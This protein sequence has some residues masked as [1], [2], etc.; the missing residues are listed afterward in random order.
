[1]IMS[2]AKKCPICRS[3]VVEGK[4]S[5]KKLKNCPYIEVIKEKIILKG[6]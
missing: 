5:Q 1:M 6:D 4:C 2:D 3:D